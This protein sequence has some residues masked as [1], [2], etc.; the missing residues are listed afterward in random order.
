MS[1]PSR[2]TD[3]TSRAGR[4]CGGNATRT[5]GESFQ[6]SDTRFRARSA[7][8]NSA[9]AS[10]V[11]PDPP[12]EVSVHVVCVGNGRRHLDVGRGLRQRFVETAGVLVGVRQVVMSPRNDPGP[13]RSPARRT[14]WSSPHCPARGR[15]GR[16]I[17][18]APRSSQSSSS[19]GNAVNDSSNSV[20]YAASLARS[21]G[22]ASAA[23]C[24]R[25]KVD[26]APIVFACRERLRAIQ[27]GTGVV[28]GIQLG[29]RDGQATVR[30]RQLRVEPQR[31]IERARRLNPDERVQVRQALIVEGLRPLETRW[32]PCRARRR[33]PCAARPGD[34]GARP[35]RPGSGGTPCGS[36]AK[37]NRAHGHDERQ[38]DCAGCAIEQRR[39]PASG[40]PEGRDSQ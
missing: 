34:S 33:C 13:R 9:I 37:P 21:P 1:H 20:R 15:P 32:T 31:L 25:T 10:S 36:C 27:G 28:R 22:A 11:R 17:P 30:H 18:Q 29:I 12:E 23:I 19:D 2:R 8:S 38:D 14:A 35:E 4:G 24:G 3:M 26:V 40:V 16:T 5:R 39:A 7:A 6:F